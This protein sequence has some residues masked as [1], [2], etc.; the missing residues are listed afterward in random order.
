MSQTAA[1]AGSIR[2]RGAGG[3]LCK[4]SSFNAPSGHSPFPQVPGQ[5]GSSHTFKLQCF[6]SSCRRLPEV[7]SCNGKTIKKILYLYFLRGSP[8]GNTLYLATFAKRIESWRK[9]WK[10]Y[11]GFSVTSISYFHPNLHEGQEM[12][13][14]YPEQDWHGMAARPRGPQ[15]PF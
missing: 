11:V 8:S 6:P 14:W 13:T 4:W 1:D 5:L 9:S 2:G 12:V 3:L 15:A 10:V 7:L